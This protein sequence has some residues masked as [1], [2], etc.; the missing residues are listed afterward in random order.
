MA[1]KIAAVKAPV[2][3]PSSSTCRACQTSAASIIRRASTGDEGAIAPTVFQLRRYSLKKAA[4]DMNESRTLYQRTKLSAN[5]FVLSH[6][7]DS[8]PMRLIRPAVL[9]IV[10][11]TLVSCGTPGYR[12]TLKD[13]RQ[14]LTASKPE[15]Q[16]KT[17]YYRYETHGGRDALIRADEVLL[18]EQE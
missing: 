3:G 2:P 12:I 10:A 18:I 14:F 4:V 17:G 1:S 16:E 11:A 7:F 9:S 8:V 13:G 15:F 6:V 5:F